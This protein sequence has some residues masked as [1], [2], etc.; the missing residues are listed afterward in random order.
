M[1]VQMN[2]TINTLGCFIISLAILA[3]IL[4][5]FNIFIRGG[6][7]VADRIL[8]DLIYFSIIVLAFDVIICLPLSFFD[9]TKEFAGKG[10]LYSSYFFGAV[11]WLWSLVIAFNLWGWVAIVIG[12]L[13]FGVG[14]VPIAFLAAL[15]A[16]LWSTLGYLILLLILTWVTRSVGIRFAPKSNGG[17]RGFTRRKFYKDNINNQHNND[18]IIDVKPINNNDNEN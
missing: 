8:P 1:Q 17:F 7:W 13:L 15:F 16:G 6:V 2:K 11:L 12:L 14:V 18:D 9:K 4:L 3:G 5:L 10:F